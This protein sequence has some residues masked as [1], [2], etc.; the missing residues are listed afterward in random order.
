[1]NKKLTTIFLCSALLALLP[2]AR[3]HAG[4]H[5]QV[6]FEATPLFS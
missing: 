2:L 4:T 5:L 1:M 6:A 3:T